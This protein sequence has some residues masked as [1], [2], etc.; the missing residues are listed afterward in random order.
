MRVSHLLLPFG[1]S[2]VC[3]AGTAKSSYSIVDTFDYTN[4]FTEFSFFTGAD[5]TG[6]FVDYQGAVAANQSGLAGFSDGAVYLGVDYKIMNPT[7]GRNSVRVGSN[8]AYAKGLFI[9]DI[10]HMPSSTCGV[11]PAFWTFGPNWPDSGEIDIIEGVNLQA[12]DSITLHASEGCVLQGS[13]S[14]ATS[15][16]STTS[17]TGDTGCSFTTANPLSY[18]SGFNAAGG[19]VYAMEWTSS[20]IQ[21]Y[22]FPRALIPADIKAGTPDPSTWG[23]PMARFSGPGCDIDSHFKNHQIVFDTTFCGNVSLFV[24]DIPHPP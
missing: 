20:A 16:L 17:C 2:M 10:A 19:G 8:R 7:G 18:G 14:L 1:A 21:V 12:T 9:A 22:F 24:L 13:G 5:P 23:M 15:V 6:G 4:F 11:W 3:A